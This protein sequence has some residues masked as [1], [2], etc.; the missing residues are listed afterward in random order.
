M[1]HGRGHVGQARA[2]DIERG[3]CGDVAWYRCTS[4]LGPLL[5]LRPVVVGKEG[6]IPLTRADARELAAMLPR[7]AEERSP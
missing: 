1:S 5:T 4:P 3:Q 6:V 2:I 7:F